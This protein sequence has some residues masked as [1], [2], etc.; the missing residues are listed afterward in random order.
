M[1]NCTKCNEEKP[2]S[3]FQK[4]KASKDGLTAACKKCLSEYD[5]ARA[6]LPHRVKAREDYRKTDAFKKSRYKTTKKYRDKNQNKTRAHRKVQYE[7]QIGNLSSK[8]CEICG[9]LKTVAHHD[10]YSR[11]LDVRWLCNK[12]HREWHRKNGEGLNP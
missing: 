4:R 3:E 9:S 8:P 5:K 6:M 11:V 7:V 2:F 10:D 12:H 1:K